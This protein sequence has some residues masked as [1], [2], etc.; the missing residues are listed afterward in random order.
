[1]YT[2]SC[3]DNALVVRVV[4]AAIRTAKDKIPIEPLPIAALPAKR[5][6]DAVVV[7]VCI[8]AEFLMLMIQKEQCHEF[9]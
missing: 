6:G 9:F 4:T 3:N 5:Y 8:I 1:M 2:G 7:I